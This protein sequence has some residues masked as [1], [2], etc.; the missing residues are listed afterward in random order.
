MSVIDK[1]PSPWYLL[2]ERPERTRTVIK[3]RGHSET[4]RG[5]SDHAQ[6]ERPAPIFPMRL[7][8]DLPGET[9]KERPD[10]RAGGRA[11]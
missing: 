6:K 1:P 3:G 11:V 10:R 5:E 2:L 4:S 8:K 7:G 9:P